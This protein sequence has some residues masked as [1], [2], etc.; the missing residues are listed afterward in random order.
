MTTFSSTGWDSWGVLCRDKSGISMIFLVP[1]NS[2]YS[3]IQFYDSI[4]V[5][6]AAHPWVLDVLIPIPGYF[7]LFG[8]V[9]GILWVT[10]VRFCV[11]ASETGAGTSPWVIYLSHRDG[12]KKAGQEEWI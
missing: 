2:G 8:H 4:N 5:K 7:S 9:S 3:I 6:C 1:Y 12:K 11:S 10:S